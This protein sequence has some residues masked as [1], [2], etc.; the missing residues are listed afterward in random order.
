MN[1][2]KKTR[3][4]DRM[5]WGVSLRLIDGA[6]CDWRSPH[7]F[8]PLFTVCL[9]VCLSKLPYLY[10]YLAFCTPVGWPPVTHRAGRGGAGRAGLFWFHIDTCRLDWIGLLRCSC[11]CLYHHRCHRRPCQC[12]LKSWSLAGGR[13]SRGGGYLLAC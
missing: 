6:S 4:R 11:V 12:V 2:N 13:A 5:V 8:S 1:K 9:S 7:F 3:G 10:P